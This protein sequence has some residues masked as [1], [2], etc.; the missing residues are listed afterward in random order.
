[1]WIR[2]ISAVCVL[3]GLLT[4]SAAMDVSPFKTGQ[5]LTTEQAR[6][7]SERYAAR[8]VQPWRASPDAATIKGRGDSDLI[9]YGIQLLDNTSATIGPLVKAAD[10]HYSGNNL[11][12]S[13]CHLKGD[14]GLPG[15]KYLGI[16]FSNVMNDYPK[17]RAR[18]MT[19]GSAADRVN[20]CMT[21]SMG[22]GRPLPVDSREMQGILAYFN[23]LSEGTE[24]GMAMEGT[25]LPRLE[26][27]ARRAN[28]EQGESVYEQF[29][30]SCHGKDAVGNRSPQYEQAAGYLF[31]PLGG[32]DSFNNGAGMSRLITAT[33][34]IFVNMPLG[35][36]ADKPALT[37]SQAYDVAA[38]IESL[39]RPE[40]PGR[41][42]DFPNPAFRPV[43]YPVPAFFNND[44]AAL[45]MA[46]YGPYSDT[47][48][49]SGHVEEH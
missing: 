27:P 1:M 18:T 15:T 44:A 36:T 45:D 9:N 32:D 48:L 47:R 39:P 26:L 29:C 11:N 46:R 14:N 20:G 3:L 6:E 49:K 42:H 16:P 4:D 30:A 24:A 28:P 41:K 40:Y 25:G 35:T 5:T 21:R 8:K 7:L 37:V 23:W 17:F 34:F 38:Y 33:Q 10:M 31:P 12:C 22:N 43:D 13:S 2:A 19:V